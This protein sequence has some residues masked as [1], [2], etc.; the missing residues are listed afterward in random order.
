MRISSNRITRVNVAEILQGTL[1]KVILI[2]LAYILGKFGEKKYRR[3]DL[4]GILYYSE[5]N[6]LSFLHSDQYSCEKRLWKS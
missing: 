5:L 2:F 3:S 1:L 4:L 6:Y